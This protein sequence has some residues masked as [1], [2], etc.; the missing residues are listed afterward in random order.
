MSSQSHSSHRWLARSDDGVHF[1]LVTDFG[2]RRS[3]GNA[4]VNIEGTSDILLIYANHTGGRKT[5][6]CL[7]YAVAE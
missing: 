7:L 6:E 3:L 1:D 4:M 5:I 2:Q